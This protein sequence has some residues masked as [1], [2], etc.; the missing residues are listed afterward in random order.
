MEMSE[1]SDEDFIPFSQSKL[2]TIKIITEFIP[3]TLN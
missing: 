3:R 1:K 2:I